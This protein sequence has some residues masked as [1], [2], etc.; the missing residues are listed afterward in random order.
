[1]KT[2]LVLLGKHFDAASQVRRRRLV[3]LVYTI[4]A[5]LMG[6]GWFI[7]H[8]HLL[9]SVLICFPAS[10]ISRLVLGLGRRG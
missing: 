2:K 6:A 1:M 5:G 8:W 4:F 10:Y 9:G 7:D 3:V